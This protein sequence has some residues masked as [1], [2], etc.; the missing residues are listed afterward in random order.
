[1]EITLHGYW[2]ST[3]S[4]RV[5]IALAL[6]KCPY[7]QATHDL[8]LG[9]QNLDSFLGVNPQGLVP[10]L[11]ADGILL[12]QS[13]AILEWLEERFPDPHLLPL[14]REHRAI[15]RGMVG[16]ICC[17]IHPLNNLRVITSLRND[18]GASDEQ[19][20]RWMSKWIQ[21]GFNALETLILTHG[22]M[23]AFGDRPTLADC[24]IVPQA[25]S[26][27]RFGVVLDAFPAI[28]ATVEHCEQ[29]PAFREAAPDAQPDSDRP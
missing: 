3:A 20:F 22:G 23:F 10:A 9:E 12:S 18:M 17:D 27:K 2:R 6:K 19:V 26:A 29:L 15:V 8:R 14:D 24:C 25:Y 5:R 21:S 13:Q 16:L 4:Y 28:L 7:S 1:M 11:D